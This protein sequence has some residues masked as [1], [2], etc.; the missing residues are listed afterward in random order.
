MTL[1]TG[2]EA[3]PEGSL[4]DDAREDGYRVLVFKSLRRSPGPV[5]DPIALVSLWRFF[6]RERPDIVHTHSSKAGI[7][8]RAAAWLAGIPVIIHT[9]HG[10]PFHPRQNW[11]VNQSWRF[12]EKLVAPATT[13]FVCVGETMKR[14]S[15]EAGLA[16]PE[17]HEVVYSGMAVPPVEHYAAS[18]ADLRPRFGIR[19]SEPVIGW[20]GRLVAQKGPWDF[21][22]VLD[23]VMSRHERVK[24]RIVGDGPLRES[25]ESEAGSKPWGHRVAFIGRVIP[26]MV[27]DYLSV[28][29]VAVLTSH[30]EGLP[31]VAVQA[32][33]AGLPVVA[34]DVQ[35]ASEV[36]RD[37]ETGF[38]VPVGDR[39]AIADRVVQVLSMPDRGRAMGAK[40]RALV[41]DQF[42]GQRMIDALV[43]IYGELT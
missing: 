15:I 19:D 25:L 23:H 10:L 7:L 26:E 6:R 11:L 14:A 38:L 40:G 9:N 22:E 2:P 18:R 20:V 32:A 24:A 12:L 36:V 4:L 28:A 13:K 30:W 39:D 37:G 21:L 34:Y 1:I 27:S 42:D 3:G 5:L 17:R 29:D 33:L 35:G 16:P 41:A 8:G 31:R 43:R